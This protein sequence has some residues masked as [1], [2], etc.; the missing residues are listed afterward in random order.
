MSVA[1]ATVLSEGRAMDPCHQLLSLE[2]EHALDRVPTARLVLLDGHVARREF[3]LSDA[4]FFAPGKRVEIALR[5]E[6]QDDAR[7]FSGLVARHGIEAR[8][9]R[10]QLFVELKDPVFALTRP[11]RSAVY[12][13]RSDDEIIG[14]LLDDAGLARGELA[15]TS[16]EHA[17]LTR[18]L[19]SDWD[20]ILSRADA[21]GLVVCVRDGALS[22]RAPGASGRSHALEFGLDEV[23][24]IDFELDGT[25]QESGLSA[26][27]WDVASQA[28]TEPAR[29]QAPATEQGIDE[30][31]ALAEALGFGERELVHAG[32]LSPDELQAWADARMRRSRLALLRG[33]AVVPG[34]ADFE[35]LDRLELGG[36][37]SRFEGG[38]LIS[39]V[40]QIFDHEGWRTE[41][42]LGLSPEWYCHRPDLRE[43]PAGGLL[44][45]ITGLQLGVVDAFEEDPEGEHRVKV[46]LP[47]FPDE[48][49][50]LW[51][52]LACPDAG[53]ERGILFW[54]EPGDEVVVGFFNADPRQA[55]VL[56]AMFSSAHAP[57]PAVGDRSEENTRRAIVSKV[58]LVVG[59][60]DDKA[61]LTLSTPGGNTIVVDDDGESITLTD[62]HGNVITMDSS[63]IK[64]E[65]AGDFI[66]DAA[67]DVQISGSAVDIN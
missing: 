3:E 27:A 63:G 1:I 49:G 12:R 46:R 34:R 39:G 62:Q 14:L 25:R 20:F 51:A 31:G 65:S 36:V 47:A 22:L 16:I 9:D 53:A 42:R 54:P 8:R 44:P 43:A 37:G 15:A 56:G 38:A 29:A 32:R 52:R 7:V 60:D 48:Q 67:G 24:E 26:V 2:V 10:M 61:A 17:E 18:Y 11:R 21:L 57:P 45:P 64:L 55:V 66:I 40:R 28:R 35:L 50:G 4:D 33:R 5:H 30:G 13:E 58:G 59:F 41:L 23:F 6:G 19:V